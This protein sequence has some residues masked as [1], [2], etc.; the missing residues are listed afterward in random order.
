MLGQ[1]SD[2]APID[3]LASLGTNAAVTH[4]A[5]KSE[6][7][8]LGMKNK[9]GEIPAWADVRFLGGLA[10]AVAAQFGGPTV[11]RVGHDAALGLLNSY[12]ATET[13]RKHAIDRLKAAGGAA[14]APAAIPESVPAAGA[15]N[16]YAYDEGSA[17]AGW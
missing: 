5:C 10:A 1:S 11:S 14:A 2:F 8:R 3:L 9:Q 16:A 17:N 15:R 7:F 6:T 13:C 4:F 12:V